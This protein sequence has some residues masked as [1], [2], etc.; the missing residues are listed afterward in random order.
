MGVNEW[1]AADSWPLPG[2]EYQDWYFHS[3]GSANSLHGNGTLSRDE[4]GAE[5]PDAFVYNPLNPVPTRGGGLCCG[6]G[7]LLQGRQALPKTVFG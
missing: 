2:T 6:R 1:R 3:Q 7:M 4:P 5:P